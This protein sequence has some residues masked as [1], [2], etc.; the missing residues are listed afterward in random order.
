MPTVDVSVATRGV[1]PVTSMVSEIWPTSIFT[2]TRRRASTCNRSLSSFS[3]LKPGSSAVTEYSPTI[4]SGTTQS[5][6][7]FVTAV[8]LW[9]VPLLVTVMATPG[10]TAPLESLTVPRIVPRKDCDNNADGNV[11]IMINAIVSTARFFIEPPSNVELRAL[12]SSL[13]QSNPCPQKPWSIFGDSIRPD[14]F[15]VFSRGLSGGGITV[16]D[17]FGARA[18]GALAPSQLR[19][20]GMVR[21]RRQSAEGNRTNRRKKK[22]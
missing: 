19:R 9:F 14:H 16:V 6:V 15:L 21:P 17:S 3:F 18:A 11:L 22:N 1:S 10:N 4:N 8:R 5:P 7:S 12:P 20:M 2:S 13:P